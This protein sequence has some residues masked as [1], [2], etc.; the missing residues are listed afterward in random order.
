MRSIGWAFALSLFAAG[1]A[2]AG[3]WAI[4]RLQPDGIG[5][6]DMDSMVVEGSI[7]TVWAVNGFP[8]SQ[9]IA[10]TRVDYFLDRY[11]IDCSRRT[12]RT[13]ES[14][15]YQMGAVFV[16]ELPGASSD[17]A[18]VPDTSGAMLVQQVCRESIHDARVDTADDA[19]RL[20]REVMADRH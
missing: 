20:F 3:E 14:R 15:L 2:Q 13:L 16:I 5:A 12:M 11:R 4:F 9:V 17:V 6:V 19:V 7:R 8:A 1:G 18:V 10:G